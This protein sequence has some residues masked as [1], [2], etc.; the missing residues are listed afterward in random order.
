[1]SMIANVVHIH[2]LDS[3]RNE[4][5]NFELLVAIQR[6]YADKLSG[7]SFRR[8]PLLALPMLHSKSRSASC[9][10]RS[11]CCRGLLRSWLIRDHLQ[12][13][14]WLYDHLLKARHGQRRCP[15]QARI[16]DVVRRPHSTGFRLHM[17]TAGKADSAVISDRAQPVCLRHVVGEVLCCSRQHG[18]CVRVCHRLR[19][20]SRVWDLR[21]LWSGCQME[22]GGFMEGHMEGQRHLGRRLQRDAL[23]W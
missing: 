2:A 17:D 3:T 15:L 9:S 23:P 12:L 18:H 4:D 13:H 21:D 1:M 19:E 20:G 7:A 10:N 5:I 16:R 11:N 8:K 6:N 22:C 14:L